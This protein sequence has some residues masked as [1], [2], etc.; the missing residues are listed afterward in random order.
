MHPDKKYYLKKRRQKRLNILY[1]FNRENKTN[2]QSE[3]FNETKKNEVFNVFITLSRN[4]KS[5][6][7][8]RILCVFYKREKN[9]EIV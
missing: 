4:N 2:P 7:C 5:F 8:H 3:P 6:T 1:F 9:I